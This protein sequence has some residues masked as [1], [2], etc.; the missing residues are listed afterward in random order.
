[1]ADDD[2]IVSF[3]DL[4]NKKRAKPPGPPPGPPS[5]T[6]PAGTNPYA[7][8][9]LNAEADNV[10]HCPKGR[11][12]A[13]LNIAAFNLGTLVPGGYLDRAV[14]ESVLRGSA[15]QC[16]LEA[17]ETEATLA[18]GLAGGVQYPRVIEE[19]TATPPNV[20]EVDASDI[21]PPGADGAAGDPVDP[22]SWLYLNIRERA[23]QDA[24]APEPT[25]LVRTDGQALLYAGND[26]LSA[27]DSALVEPSDLGSPATKGRFGTELTNPAK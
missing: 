27:E 8:A 20:I 23:I 25:Y 12:N 3:D 4:W 9:A 1:M 26:G 15:H 2:N 10:A 24:G 21:L 5:I 17:G 22:T 19:S 18:S 7:L 16:G 14:I 13:T 11:R 6:G